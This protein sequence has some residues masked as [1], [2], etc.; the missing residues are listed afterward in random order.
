M[1]ARSYVTTPDFKG[2]SASDFRSIRSTM[3]EKNIITPD[4]YQTLNEFKNYIRGGNPF[5]R[6]LDARRHLFSA[7]SLKAYLKSAGVSTANLVWDKNQP[8][9]GKVADKK[10]ENLAD[11]MREAVLAT[12]ELRG[13][14]PDEPIF[15]NE[16]G[17]PVS[18]GL[19]K[20]IQQIEKSAHKTAVPPPV[21]RTSPKIEIH[22]GFDPQRCVAESFNSYSTQELEALGQ[23]YLIAFQHDD[24][25]SS[26][27]AKLTEHWS[28]WMAGRL[29]SFFRER[30]CTERELG[31]L[32]QFAT[33]YGISSP[34]SMS[35]TELC[36]ALT[37]KMFDLIL[38]SRMIEFGLGDIS[39]ETVDLIMNGNFDIA[40]QQLSQ[41]QRLGIILAASFLN[42]GLMN[43]VYVADVSD[44]IIAGGLRSEFENVQKG[45]SFIHDATVSLDPDEVDELTLAV[46]DII[47]EEKGVKAQESTENVVGENLGGISEDL[48]SKAIEK[49]KAVEPTPIEVSTFT[50]SVIPQQFIQNYNNVFEQLIRQYHPTGRI[51]VPIDDAI[52]WVFKKFGVRSIDQMLPTEEARKLFADSSAIVEELPRELRN[53][54]G[55]SYAFTSGKNMV[56]NID[57][58][59]T[60]SDVY[61]YDGIVMKPST[62]SRLEEIIAEPKT[63]KKP[64]VFTVTNVQKL[65]KAGKFSQFLNYVR[66]YGLETLVNN[67]TVYAFNDKAFRDIRNWMERDATPNEQEI[68]IKLHIIPSGGRDSGKFNTAH[69]GSMAIISSMKYVEGTIL[70]EIDE[71]LYEIDRAI[72]L[73]DIQ[74]QEAADRAEVARGKEDMSPAQDQPK[75]SV[76]DT[77][78]SLNE[79]ET[80]STILFASGLQHLFDSSSTSAF[81]PSDATISEAFR[82]SNVTFEDFMDD[83]DIRD[84]FIRSTLNPSDKNSMSPTKTEEADKGSAVLVID[85]IPAD[86]SDAIQKLENKLLFEDGEKDDMIEVTQEDLI[87]EE[88]E[89]ERERQRIIEEVKA[90]EAAADLAEKETQD[91]ILAEKMAAEEEDRRLAE[92][93][94]TQQEEERA[95][96]AA[97]R[98]EEDR[99]L[100]EELAARQ[101]EERR[102]EEAIKEDTLALQE[103][104][105]PPG[106]RVVGTGDVG[107]LPPGLAEAV[108]QHKVGK[109]KTAE[110]VKPTFESEIDPGKVEPSSEATQSE[111]EKEDDMDR[112]EMSGDSESLGRILSPMTDM[113]DAGDG[114]GF[115]KEIMEA[116][117]IDS[118]PLG[119]NAF[120]QLE[121]Y[122]PVVIIAPEDDTLSQYFGVW[123]AEDIDPAEASKFLA[124]HIAK[125]TL[126]MTLTFLDGVERSINEEFE[127][128]ESDSARGSEP[129]DLPDGSKI[130]YVAD[131]AEPDDES[132][133]PVIEDR[134]EQEQFDEPPEPSP[135]FTSEPQPLPTETVP[136][137]EEN[138]DEMDDLLE[139]A[140]RAF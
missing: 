123:S 137:K 136:T 39:T 26:M 52:D 86:L 77:I 2:I 124:S 18:P 99:R 23:K 24:D 59:K 97:I 120:E 31:Q 15:D 70:S 44:P 63:V 65:E 7:N 85:E 22:A 54:L 60:T 27:C 125:N 56:E 4:Q 51:I 73:T 135:V 62:K 8:V 35:K 133:G 98:E 132:T 126:G 108:A 90:A 96:L 71:G 106:G 14:L 122:G 75:K 69:P 115:F 36:E 64:E 127:I 76:V 130:Y 10:R 46:A 107:T 72:D 50:P 66:K 88:Q 79:L 129:V 89:K 74:N 119:R 131:I 17:P 30:Q 33:D 57:I 48:V 41:K 32:I 38:T 92:Q 134:D 81:I 94:A 34:A 20:F 19:G 95:R 61:Y 91:R 28:K 118:L 45:L 110:V 82:G 12:N 103:P 116:H 80:F 53:A 87:R 128:I 102:Q 112:N 1:S 6:M 16:G 104:P 42:P 25:K 101:E 40:S 113:V 21:E 58:V 139:M 55:E 47:E 5:A 43:Y 114:V 9:K 117:T 109:I 121:N 13:V 37:R 83:S 3:I 138:F 105:M 67:S 49:A 11:V 78:N 140:G 29:R 84:E 111:T 68:I 100:A 93:L